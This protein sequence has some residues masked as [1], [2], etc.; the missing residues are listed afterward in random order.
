M[1]LFISG[2]RVRLCGWLRRKPSGR[3]IPPLRPVPTAHWHS[4]CIITS[5]GT[6]PRPKN[7]LKEPLKT[8]TALAT[9][10]EFWMTL[11]RPVMPPRKPQS[12]SRNVVRSW[13]RKTPPSASGRQ[14]SSRSG[15]RKLRQRMRHRKKQIPCMCSAG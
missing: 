1:L 13:R 4:S 14:S 8:A 7:T 10:R 12:S 6:S 2:R 15:S 5:R 11:P 9:P 3:A